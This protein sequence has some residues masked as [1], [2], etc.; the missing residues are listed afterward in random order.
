[1]ALPAR[2]P[3]LEALSPELAKTFGVGRAEGQVLAL[4]VEA[5][6]EALGGGLPKGAM[7]EIVGA[8]GHSGEWLAMRA[9]AKAGG[10][11][12]VLDHDGSFFPPGAQACGVE[13]S[14]LLVVRESRRKEALWA[15]ERL[16]REPGLAVVISWLDGLT[17]TF[18]RRLQLAAERSGQVLLLLREQAG[19]ATSWGALRLLVG[20]EPGP[21]GAR[22]LTVETLRARGGRMPRPVRIEVEDGSG[23]V[24][25]ASLLSHRAPAS[26]A[27][28]A[29]RA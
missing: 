29:A 27:S 13:L 21:R 28:R 9:L 24:R 26:L 23:V 17:E 18:L 7:T 2:K 19:A 4:G 14:R 10:L 3:L 12:A 25:G 11:G 16:V 15:L 1:M 5:L 22:Q 8:S 20:G 6:D